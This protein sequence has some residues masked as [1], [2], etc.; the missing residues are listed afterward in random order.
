MRVVAVSLV[1]GLAPTAAAD[2]A[3]AW[4]FETNIRT[5][6]CSINGNMSIGIADAAGKRDCVFTS[7]ETCEWDLPGDEGTTVDQS[8]RVIEQGDYYLITSKVE[9]S[10]TAGYDA[11][12]YLPDHFTVKP[13]AADRM[14]GQ[15]YDRNYRDKVTFWRNREAPIS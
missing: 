7:T 14:A 13:V 11:A 9:R 12:Y 6:G 8:C 2:I 1:L 10:L 15:W 5:K 4:T 3:G